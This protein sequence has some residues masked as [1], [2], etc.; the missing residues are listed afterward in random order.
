MMKV[1]VA[2]VFCPAEAVVRGLKEEE[3]VGLYLTAISSSDIKSMRR[4]IASGLR[5]TFNFAIKKGFMAYNPVDGIAF[6]PVEKKIKYI[7][8]TEDIDKVISMA[9]KDVQDYLWTIRKT[10]KIYSHSFNETEK[11]AIRDYEAA[12]QKS[13]T[14]PHTTKKALNS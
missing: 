5:A 14:N 7:P 1:R 12:R 9:S 4:S 11:Q 13:H 3:P 10:T 6:L 8:P 2:V